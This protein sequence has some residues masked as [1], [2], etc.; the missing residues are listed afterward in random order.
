MAKII[1]VTTP[2][3]KKVLVN[4]RWIEQ[5][6]EKDSGAAVYFAFNMPNAYEQD[7]LYTKESYKEEIKMKVWGCNGK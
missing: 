4:T 6:E 3:G 2:D 1:E 5:I 7:Y